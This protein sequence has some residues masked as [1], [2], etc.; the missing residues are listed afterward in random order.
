MAEFK[1]GDRVY[2]K[3]GENYGRVGRVTEVSFDRARDKDLETRL[4]AYCVKFD[5]AKIGIWCLENELGPAGN[6]LDPVEATERFIK[7]LKGKEHKTVTKEAAELAEA[8]TE[9]GS[10]MKSEKAFADKK[11]EYQ[12]GF[13]AGYETR[14]IEEITEA[15]LNAESYGKTEDGK[16]LRSVK[17]ILEI[18]NK[19]LP[20]E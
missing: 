10:E 18:L 11:T 4:P 19:H 20:C 17:D 9:E 1:C 3:K 16:E 15:V 12:K 5:G 2:I 13:A 14:K 8:R 6:L 7:Y